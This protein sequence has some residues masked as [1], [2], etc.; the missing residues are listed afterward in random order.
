MFAHR[1]SG[2]LIIT[3]LVFNVHEFKGLMAPLV[4]RM[5]GAYRRLAQSRLYRTQ[6]KDREAFAASGKAIFA[7]EFD[8][9]VMAHGDPLIEPNVD[10]VS[11]REQL[12]HA[13]AWM[14][15]GSTA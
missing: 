1:A 11:P 14:L 5:V 7:L 3:D 8:K 4:F 10:G 6:V 12:E 2:A 9:V 13:L 15:A